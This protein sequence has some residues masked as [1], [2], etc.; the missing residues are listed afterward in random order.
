MNKHEINQNQSNEYNKSTFVCLLFY[1]ILFFKLCGSLTAIEAI[2]KMKPKPKAND[3]K[4]S[5][6]VDTSMTECLHFL[7]LPSN[8]SGT[9][10]VECLDLNFICNIIY[11]E[12]LQLYVLSFLMPMELAKTARVNFIWKEMVYDDVLWKGNI[13]LSP[14]L[15]LF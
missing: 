8:L 2:I 1:D 13:I 6:I 3:K 14:L 4:S 7:D 15:I 11:L 10:A 5:A 12:E 9:I